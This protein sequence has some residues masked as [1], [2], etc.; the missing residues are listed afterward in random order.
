[1]ERRNERDNKKKKMN[2]KKNAVENPKLGINGYYF[3]QVLTIPSIYP[4]YK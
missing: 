3:T 4:L 2:K 1:M